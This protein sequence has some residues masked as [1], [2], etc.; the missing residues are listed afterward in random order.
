MAYPDGYRIVQWAQI[1]DGNEIF[2]LEDNRSKPYGPY[3]V[4]DRTT[5]TVEEVPAYGSTPFAIKAHEIIGAPDTSMIG[6]SQA[7]TPGMSTMGQSYSPNASKAATAVASSLA[8]ALFDALYT[9]IASETARHARS[10]TPTAKQQLDAQAQSARE[11]AIKLLE[12]ALK[13]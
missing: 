8:S 2:I 4:V 13:R 7:P 3:R 1:V 11:A 5:R 9:A 6:A 10:L 12:D